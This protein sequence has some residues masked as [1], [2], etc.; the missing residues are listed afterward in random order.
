MPIIDVEIVTGDSESLPTELAQS[1]ANAFGRLLGTP[2]GHTWVRVRRLPTSAY[3]EN[4]GDVPEDHPFRPIFVRVLH[5]RV[6]A[7]DVRRSQARSIA[8][9]ASRLCGRRPENVHVLFEPEAN[10]RIAFGGRLVESGPEDD[11][12]P[13]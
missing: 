13:C 7:L 2:S 9:E 1:L 3:A 6:P 8:E 12:R 4:T 11:V 10:G 5:R